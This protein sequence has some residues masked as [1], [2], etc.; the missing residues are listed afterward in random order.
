M[1]IIDDLNALTP[2]QYRIL[3]VAFEQDDGS[4]TAHWDV[5]IYNVNGRELAVLHPT[6]QPDMALR[7]ALVSW[8]QASKTQFETA[9][10][11]T[12]YIS[13]EPLP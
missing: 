13:E 2:A 10:G 4:I 8:Y 9:T 11:L 3:R 1:T 5:R 12:E 7:N 6:S